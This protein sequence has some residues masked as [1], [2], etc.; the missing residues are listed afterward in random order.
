VIEKRL[1]N[2]RLEVSKARSF[3]F[4]I[5]NSSFEDAQT[6]LQ[7]VVRGQRLRYSAQRRRQPQ[8]FAALGL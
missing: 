8:V 3:D 2:A 6:E 7:T 1:A 4:V 5:I